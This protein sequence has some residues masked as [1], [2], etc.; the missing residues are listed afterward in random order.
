MS[1]DSGR[2]AVNRLAWMRLGYVALD[3]FEVPRVAKDC[4]RGVTC[5]TMRDE[6]LLERAGCA[7]LVTRLRI[8]YDDGMLELTKS[9]S[10]GV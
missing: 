10:F 4:V 1:L 2:V 3:R 7:R 9:K 5:P 8:V 6:A